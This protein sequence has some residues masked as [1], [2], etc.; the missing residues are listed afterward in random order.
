MR[1]G[2]GTSGV[3]VIA[4]AAAIAAAATTFPDTHGQA[5]GAFTDTTASDAVLERV[6]WAE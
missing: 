6:L 3:V 2:D 4:G 1:L 5:Y